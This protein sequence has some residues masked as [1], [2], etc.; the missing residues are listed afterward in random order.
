M[1]AKG[2]LSEKEIEAL[3]DKTIMHGGKV[4]NKTNSDGSKSMNISPSAVQQ[5]EEKNAIRLALTMKET[6][7]GKS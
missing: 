2:L 4:S 3:I 5:R 6:K 1:P 7:T